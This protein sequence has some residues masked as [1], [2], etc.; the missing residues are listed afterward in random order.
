MASTNGN[1]RKQTEYSQTDIR[2]KFIKLDKPTDETQPVLPVPP[3]V[4]HL[5]RAKGK[6]VQDCDVYI[7]RACNMGGWNLPQSK[8]HNPF[9]VKQYGRDGAL[10]KFRKHIESNENNLL[11]DLHEL[12]GKRLGCWCKP[13]PCHG[14]ILCE[15]FKREIQQ[16]A[17]KI[18]E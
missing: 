2:S 4:V 17:K 1:K 5:R 6:V 9:S 3:T 15:L 10:E 7:A 11:N 16:S 13:K 8:W 14:D 18:S 12:E